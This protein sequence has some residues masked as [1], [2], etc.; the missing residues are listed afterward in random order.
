M[1]TPENV[2]N[3]SIR[4]VLQSARSLR[5][6]IGAKD[7]ALSRSFYRAI[8]FE[9]A[10]ISPDMSVFTAGGQAFYLQDYYVREWVDNT[11]LFL[12]VEDADRCW[13]ALH[14]LDLP[15]RF[16]GARL[17]P[18]RAESWGRECFLHD[19]SGVLWHFGQ[20]FD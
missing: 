12:E 14:A 10:E 6:F 7:F 18:V 3:E 5:P 4:P 2:G 8:G 16:P 11:M 19:P 20:F 13:E 9:E 1:H 15:A 17:L